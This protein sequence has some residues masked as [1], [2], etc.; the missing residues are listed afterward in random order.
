MYQLVK[1]E[2]FIPIDG[3]E[4]VYEISNFGRVKSHKGKTKFLQGSINK[5]YRIVHLM[6]DHKRYSVMVH[7]LVA[8]YFLPKINGKNEINHIDGNKL[9]CCVE[10]LEWCTHLENVQHAFKTGLVQ[11]K[12]LNEDQKKRISEKTKDA[13]KRKDVQVKLHK[14]RPNGKGAKRSE[15]TKEK[16]RMAWIRRKEVQNHVI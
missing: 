9:N 10:N 8:E 16:M 11:R 12:P 4:G 2:I 13:M 1:K 6:K 14:E 7:R 15:E 3:F 5:G